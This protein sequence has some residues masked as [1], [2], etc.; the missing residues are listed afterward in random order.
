MRTALVTGGAQGIG[1]GIV[2]RLRADGWR[3]AVMDRDVEALQEIGASDPGLLVLHADV[4]VEADVEG[5]LSMLRGW[6]EGAG[7]GLLVSNAGIA[8]P[9]S[10]PI[11]DLSLERWRAWQDSHVTGA[12]LTIRGCVPLLRAARGSIVTMASTRALQSEPDTESYAAAKGALVALTHALAVSLGPAIRANCILPG[13]IDTSL[14]RKAAD[15]HT[16]DLS[17]TD[18]RQHP[19]GRVGRVDDIAG[20]VAWLASDEAGFVTGQRFVVDG[21]MSVRMIYAD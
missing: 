17:E 13:W 9:V 6:L 4:G 16:P 7:L 5:A 20:L 1:R 3:I 18:H 21:G 8:G 12:F 11:E 14:A 10:G 2:T 19:V 15:R